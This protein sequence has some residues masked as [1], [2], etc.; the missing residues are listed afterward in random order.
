MSKFCIPPKKGLQNSKKKLQNSHIAVPAEPSF[1][2]SQIEDV[3]CTHGQCARGSTAITID[4]C[5]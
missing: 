4:L 1:P 5:G 3:Q 2:T